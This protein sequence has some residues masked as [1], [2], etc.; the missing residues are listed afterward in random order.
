MPD[1]FSSVPIAAIALCSRV[2]CALLFLTSLLVFGINWT[3]LSHHSDLAESPV[4][5]PHHTLLAVLA[6]S[7]NTS[8]VIPTLNGKHITSRPEQCAPVFL[9]ALVVLFSS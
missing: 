2:Y 5:H 1:H 4:Y 3:I 8:S 9:V 6:I 7:F